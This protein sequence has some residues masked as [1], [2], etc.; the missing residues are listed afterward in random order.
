MGV[1][2]LGCKLWQ[3]RSDQQSCSAALMGYKAEQLL[4]T[5]FIVA[6]SPFFLLIYI[7]FKKEGWGYYLN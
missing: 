2:L 4:L 5:L 6:P 1:T 3:N 7:F